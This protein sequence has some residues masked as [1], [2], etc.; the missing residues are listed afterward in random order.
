MKDNLR[1]KFDSIE[2]LTGEI[3]QETNSDRLFNDIDKIGDEIDSG[4][5]QRKQEI[6]SLPLEEKKKQALTSSD[7]FVINLLSTVSNPDVKK[8]IAQNL[9]VPTGIMRRFLTEG[10]EMFV[11]LLINP[12]LP[13]EFLD[14]IANEKISDDMSFV[15]SLIAFHP[16]CNDV[17]RE[18]YE[19]LKDEDGLTGDIHSFLTEFDNL[20]NWIAK[21]FLVED[22]RINTLLDHIGSFADCNYIVSE[23]IKLWDGKK[24]NKLLKKLEG[25]ENLNLS[26]EVAKSLSDGNTSDWVL[27]NSE[28]FPDLT[29]DQTVA[30]KLFKKDGFEVLSD[31][32][33]KFTFDD[34]R[35]FIIEAIGFFPK[36]SN[37][38]RTIFSAI[39]EIESF[40]KFLFEKEILE[41]YLTLFDGYNNSDVADV[42]KKAKKSSLDE[43]IAYSLINHKDYEYVIEN[44]DKFINIGFC[45]GFTYTLIRIPFRIW[46]RNFYI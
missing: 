7:P 6:L 10:R 34:P 31:H 27:K 39:F 12:N 9:N 2:S 11:P 42:L 29:F 8:K 26:N 36:N 5:E 41:P 30:T 4:I 23:I 43:Y 22:M 35:G 33:A 25:I 38:L 24:R 14:K 28:K 18:K 37:K 17:L 3:I 45:R 46:I 1:Q 21:T 20:P 16:N 32:I 13:V 15:N 40:R 44:I 19:F